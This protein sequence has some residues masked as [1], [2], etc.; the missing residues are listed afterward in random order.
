M[1]FL[2]VRAALLLSLLLLGACGPQAFK[3]VDWQDPAYQLV[4]P[5]PPDQPRLQYLRSISGPK[6]IRAEDRSGGVLRWLVG[7]DESDLPL[8]APFAV[9][10]EARG[11]V[12]VADGGARMLYRIDMARRTVDYLQEIEGV[13][14]SN[15][16]GVAVDVQRGRVYLADAALDYVFELDLDGRYLGRRTPP[17]GFRRPSGMAVAT[18]GRL[19]VADVLDGRVAVFGPDGGFQKY[20]DS[21]VDPSGR[22]NRPL[23]VALGPAGEILVVDAMAFRIEIQDQQG[24]LLGT[25]GQLG[26]GPGSFARPRGV[27]VNRKGQVFVSDAAFDNVQVFDLTGNLLLYFGGAG[28]RAGEFNL[29]AGLFVDAEDR[30]FVAD[31]YNHRVQVFQWLDSSP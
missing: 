28:T 22:F 17:G 10:A 15:P 12:W 24:G 6:D 16:S 9:A 2:A 4:W 19:L 31:S 14:L 5:E 11:V 13:R 27:A 30:L 23:A 29:P 1:R 8:L 26:D 21:K 25:I 20:I 18:D 7:E 3:P